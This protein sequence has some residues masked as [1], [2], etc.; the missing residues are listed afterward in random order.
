[1]KI[2]T[3]HSHS[4]DIYELV[5]IFFPGEEID[6]VKD[7]AD[8]VSV[9]DGEKA[10]SKI[11]KG[12]LRQENSENI[13]D[14]PLFKKLGNWES[15]LLKYSL[16]K[17]LSQKEENPWGM[18]TG[19]RP[20][21][22]ARQIKD[23][24]EDVRENLEKYFF[25]APD[26]ADLLAGIL[27]RQEESIEK[28]KDGYSLYIN[29]PFCP[30]IC[31]YCSYPVLPIARYEDI[32]SQYVE[33][34]IEEINFVMDHHGQPSM[35]YIGGGTPSAIGHVDLAKI[36]DTV[37]ARSKPSE[38]TVEIGREDTITKDLLD[39]LAN[40]VDRI[41]INPQSMVDESVKLIGR[42]QGREGIIR[43]FDLARKYDFIINMDT[44]IGLPNEGIEEVSMTFD[45][46]IK[47]G[48]ENITVHTLSMKK[49]SRLTKKGYQSDSQIAD[50]IDL[51]KKILMDN[52]YLPYYLYRQKNILEG[53]EN[54]GYSKE[55]YI[56]SY[57]V[58]SMEE[59]QTIIGTGMG[60]V[61]K[62]VFGE[63]AERVANFKSM[64]DYLKRFDEILQRKLN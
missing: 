29:I 59:S 10:V 12:D 44:I 49:G 56:C 16:Y 61:S 13:E 54:I 50:M 15:K 4:H 60:A 37:L 27:D 26:R 14:F 52:G 35:V 7:K 11:M 42:K 53:Q 57:N 18:L 2:L 34:L 51:T 17:L 36:I 24:G 3:N 21:K 31:A 5:R 1:M 32:A 64:N 20:G 8:V 9:L 46:L 55:G 63:R 28:Y 6:L 43:A 40:R 45:D 19:M 48:P 62:F 58:V 23:Q 41:C 25:L 39:M 22:L 30:S 47:L 38:F 33:K